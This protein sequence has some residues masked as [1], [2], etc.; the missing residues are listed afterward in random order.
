[1]EKHIPFFG[2]ADFPSLVYDKPWSRV[3]SYFLGVLFSFIWLD[4]VHALSITSSLFKGEK[5]IRIPLL[6]RMT[7]IIVGAFLIFITI[8]G[9]YW[10][11]H[12]GTWPQPLAAAYIS[13]SRSAFLIGVG[14]FLFLNLNGYLVL[15]N[16][17][18][19]H[20]IWTPLARLTFLTYLVHPMVM[21][22][23][24]GDSRSAVSYTPISTTVYFVAF[25]ALSYFLALFL[26]LLV[27]KPLMNMEK[28]F[29]P[30]HV[31]TREAN[32]GS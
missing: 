8:Y 13:L 27:E 21:D 11:Y 20:S 3:A 16:R 2:T 30:H 23:I 14:V 7:A 31:T 5:K 17:F 18:F 19:S 22:T 25:C 6:F 10:N 15:F 1:M 4:M 24:Y 29:I 12:P 28:L 32:K 26:W 9:T